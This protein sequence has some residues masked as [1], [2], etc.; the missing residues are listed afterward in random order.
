M[1]CS[2]PALVLFSTPPLPAPSLTPSLLASF[3]FS[4]FC[5]LLLCL[6]LFLPPPS[7]LPPSVIRFLSFCPFV[8]P[9]FFGLSS[10][11][12]LALTL[13]DLSF[14]PSLAACHTREHFSHTFGPSSISLSFLLAVVLS[15]F[16]SILHLH[17]YLTPSS[18]LAPA[19]A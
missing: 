2:L 12:Y 15:D 10:S 16:N 1:N 3:S 11:F 7:F 8:C 13:P 6:F 5:F 19:S 18:A 14:H 9:C 17:A 4:L